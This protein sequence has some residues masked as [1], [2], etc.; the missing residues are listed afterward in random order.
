MRMIDRPKGHHATR[1]LAAVSGAIAIVWAATLATRCPAQ[2]TQPARAPD[3]TWTAPSGIEWATCAGGGAPAALVVA[4]RDG[5]LEN[6]DSVAGTPRSTQMIAAARGVRLAPSEDGAA[7]GAAADTGVAYCFDRHAAYALRLTEPAGLKWQFGARPAEGAEY[8]GDPENLTGWSLAEAT[9]IGLLLVNSSGR[10]V[11]LANVDGRVRWQL[12]VGRLPLARLHVR[13]AKAVV[14]EKL[15]GKV[16]AVFLP[17]EDEQP[18]SAIRELGGQWPIW[19]TLL[20]GGLL[21]ISPPTVNF[22]PMDGPGRRLDMLLPDS[23]TPV[24]GVFEP[25]VRRGAERTPALHPGTLLFV[26]EGGSPAAYDLA[27]GSRIW[28]N[29]S[30]PSAQ[31]RFS[32]LTVAGERLVAVGAGG[33][34]VYAARTGVVLADAGC[35]GEGWRTVGWHLTQQN[36][37]AVARDLRRPD[38]PIV[39]VCVELVKTDV[40][41]S[42]A[43]RETR[44]AVD[45]RGAGVV[46]DVVWTSQHVVLVE[47]NALRAYTLP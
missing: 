22:W 17:L 35:A 46:R 10:V 27:T 13:G 32:A 26:G 1:P 8:P 18:Q 9:E 11:L 6:I 15:A 38:A 37:Y 42:K 45:L 34:V 16:R 40:P 43:L 47:P 20:S 33:P 31:S 5:R 36:L 14:L 29:A 30:Q 23:E 2:T 39:L 21:T 41:A 7:D 24:L 28:P 4:L 25:P 44:T 12:E 3:W 19:S